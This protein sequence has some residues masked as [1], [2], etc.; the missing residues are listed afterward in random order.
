MLR[1]HLVF[2]SGRDFK[3]RAISIRTLS[4][5]SHVALAISDDH[6]TLLHT[7]DKGVIAEPREAWIGDTHRLLAEYEILPDVSRNVAYMIAQIGKPYDIPWLF[8][9]EIKFLLARTGSPLHAIIPTTSSRWTCANF[10]LLLARDGAIPEWTG[11][12]EQTVT[13]VDLWR[14]LG[15]SF[16]RVA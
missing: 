13:P 2:T 4:L 16:R 3:S 1:P 9:R 15:A 6:R 10:I 12:D 14:N 8:V 7:T 5:A 11:L